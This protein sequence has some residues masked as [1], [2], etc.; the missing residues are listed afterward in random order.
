[1][2]FEVVVV[3]VADGEQ[4]AAEEEDTEENSMYTEEEEEEEEQVE[5][6]EKAKV[7]TWEEKEQTI[8]FITQAGDHQWR[9][10]DNIKIFSYKLRTN[11]KMKITCRYYVIQLIRT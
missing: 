6:G 5:Y 4:N 1:M 3:V 10:K 7:V 9:S 8:H 2:F 11:S